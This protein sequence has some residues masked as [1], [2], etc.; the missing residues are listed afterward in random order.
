MAVSQQK[1]VS[2]LSQIFPPKHEVYKSEPTV[3]PAH[4]ESGREGSHTDRKSRHGAASSLPPFSWDPHLEDFR[5]TPHPARWQGAS[6]SACPGRA[7][8]AATCCPPT[9]APPHTACVSHGASSQIIECAPARQVPV[10]QASAG[11]G[12]VGSLTRFLTVCSLI[13]LHYSFSSAQRNQ[14]VLHF[15]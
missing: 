9:A 7:V 15:I 8:T 12:H 13:S 3:A 2:S 14:A 4:E 10:L 1:I 6:S 5:T 11:I